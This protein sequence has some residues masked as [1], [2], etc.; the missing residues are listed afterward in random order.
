LSTQKG[1]WHSSL[2]VYQ[3]LSARG[4]PTSP[5][6]RWVIAVSDIFVVRERVFGGDN[7]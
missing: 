1:C 4:A 6:S 5:Y 2:R 3:G 7:A